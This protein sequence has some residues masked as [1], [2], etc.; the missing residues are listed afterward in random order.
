MAEA[1]SV[2][3]SGIAVAQVAAQVGKSIIKLKQLWDELQHVPST[4]GDLLD[5]IECLDPA[6]WE[7]E[8]TF[9]QASLPPMFWDNGLASR[10]TAYCRKALGSLTELVDDLTLQINRPGKFRSKIASAK[11]VL[12][13]EQLKT[14][15]RRLQNAIRMLTLAQQSYLVLVLGQ[16]HYDIH[17]DNCSSALTRVQPDIIVQSFTE[18][19]TPLIVQTLQREFQ[20]GQLE[21]SDAYRRQPPSQAIKPAVDGEVEN[22]VLVP[23]RPPRRRGFKRSFRFR[24]LWLSQTTWELQSSRSYGN[25]KLNLRCYNTVSMYSKVFQIAGMG[26]PRELQTLCARGLASPYDRSDTNGETLLLVSLPIPTKAKLISSI[27]R[28]HWCTLIDLWSNTYS[29]SA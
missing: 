13:K 23:R 6:L 27:L 15:E 5:Q 21:S 12:K 19:T 2:A 8:N 28:W 1:L 24:L 26:T 14:L 4:I 20:F 18:I 16:I 10:S 25:W 22:N 17:I 3:A 29:T 11:V 7:A 9:D